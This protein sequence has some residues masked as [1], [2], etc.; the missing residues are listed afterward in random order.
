MTTVH[1]SLGQGKIIES[2]TSRGRTMHRVEGPGFS[3][4]FYSNEIVPG[5]HEHINEREV[6][7][8][9]SVVLPYNPTPQFPDSV[10]PDESTL[11][12]VYELD[13]DERLENIDS[14]DVKRISE[15]L[16][17]KFVKIPE[18]KINR[19]SNYG[20]MVSD[21]ERY[22]REVRGGFQRVAEN[23]QIIDLFYLM[24]SDNTVRQAAWKDVRAKAVRLRKSGSVNVQEITPRAIHALVQGDN[25]VYD[26]V[27]VR[28]GATIGSGSVTEWACSCPWGQH[29]FTRKH[30]YVGRLCSHAY[31]AYMEL[32]A[33]SGSK[34]DFNPNVPRRDRR[35]T[36]LQPAMLPTRLQSRVASELDEYDVRGPLESFVDW[37]QDDWASPLVVEE[38]S[39]AHGLSESE[40]ND[41]TRRVDRLIETLETYGD[42]GSF[43]D[44]VL[45]IDDFCDNKLVEAR[46]NVEVQNYIP[47]RH[48]R[49]VVDV[50]EDERTYGIVNEGDEYRVAGGGLLGSD[51]RRHGP[52]P[53]SGSGPRDRFNPETSKQRADREDVMEDVTELSDDTSYT[54]T[55]RLRVA[56]RHFSLQ[57][58]LD[59]INEAQGDDEILGRLDLRGTHYEL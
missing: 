26:T 37:A 53:F 3:K 22:A 23:A 31:A 19:D 28:G 14:L 18:A 29:A 49:T 46:L 30:T 36:P 51:D 35:K 39:D 20:Q 8:E 16:G 21:P 43:E 41:L 40:E 27:V 24:D 11:Q 54:R 12:P 55:S 32:Q 33:N 5:D 1:T 6:D 44:M 59:L 15:K 57:E 10:L 17:P 34:M 56:G 52:S 38:Y 47:R 2:S 25:G 58:Q 13:E 42:E 4:W 50:E 48:E 9:N 7:E 45:D